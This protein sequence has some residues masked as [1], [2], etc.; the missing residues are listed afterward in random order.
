YNRKLKAIKR[1]QLKNNLADGP[2]GI[3]EQQNLLQ[4]ASLDTKNKVSKKKETRHEEG[5]ASKRPFPSND[6]VININ[7]DGTFSRPSE[8]E[9]LLTKKINSA[10]VSELEILASD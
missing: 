5:L 1:A 2:N 4:T 3:Q 7:P 10:R 9:E 8:K 6:L